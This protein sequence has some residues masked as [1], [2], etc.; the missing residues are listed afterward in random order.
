MIER[1]IVTQPFFDVSIDLVG[2]FPKAVGGYTHLVTCIDT[3]TRWP[4][5]VPMTSATAKSVINCL[6]NTFSRNGFPEKVT[7]DNGAQFTS[8]Q[9]MSKD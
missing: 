4:D 5:A 9:F 1:P 7:S 8:K 3:A 2:P 6:T